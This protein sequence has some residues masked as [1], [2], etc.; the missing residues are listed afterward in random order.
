[1]DASALDDLLGGSARER[2]ESWRYS[3][4]AIR[5]LTQQEFALANTQAILSARTLQKIDLPFT[6]GRRVVFVNGGYSERYSDVGKL[7]AD[8]VIRRESAGSLAIT[9]R[10]DCADPLHL[11]YVSVPADSA[12]RWQASSEIEL[13][14]GH[15]ELIE[16]HVGEA[17]ADVF[18]A[19]SVRTTLAARAELHMTCIADLPDCI[20]LL[21]KAQEAIGESATL[22]ATH[23]HFGG[24]LQ[25]IESIIDLAARHAACRSR[26]VFA[27][28]GREHVDVHLQVRHA[29]RDTTSNVF[30]R[31]VADQRARGVFHGAITV[32]AGADGADAQLSNKNLLL[33]AQAEIDTQPVLEIYADEVKAAHGATVG[34]LDEHAL[35]YLRSRGVPAATARK[36]LISAFCREVFDALANHELRDQLDALLAAR[37][38]AAG[39]AAA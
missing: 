15:A 8:I 36:L 37:L 16:Q 9:I 1:M 19:L 3:K 6:R 27:L 10:S 34:Q 4:N 38:P 2:E 23:A 20:S 35:F 26:G 29:A 17:G 33:S 24:R 11:V 5:A 14:G 7:Q 31:G 13:Q 18:G 12:S 21:R 39:E 32:A 22:I 30:W 25:R 28:R